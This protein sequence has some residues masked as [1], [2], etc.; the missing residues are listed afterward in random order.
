M[1]RLICSFCGTSVA[2][3][4][5]MQSRIPCFIKYMK[6]M[7]EMLMHATEKAFVMGSAKICSRLLRPSRLSGVDS[8]SASHYNAKRVKKKF[9]N[10]H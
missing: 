10:P 3:L 8:V 7:K 2:F 1:P 4:S 6:T 5:I 9:A